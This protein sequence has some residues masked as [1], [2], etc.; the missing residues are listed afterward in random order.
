MVKKKKKS[1][2]IHRYSCTISGET[3]KVT[4]EAKNPN[5]L[6]S[7]KAYYELHPEKDDR[8]DVIKVK[9]GIPLTSEEAKS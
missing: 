4:E 5:D 8:P 2:Q 6:V 3:Y 1:K 9:L 7:V